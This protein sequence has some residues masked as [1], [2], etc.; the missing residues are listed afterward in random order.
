MLRKQNWLNWKKRSRTNGRQCLANC[1]SKNDTQLSQLNYCFFPHHVSFFFI[2]I[3]EY[4]T[5]SFSYRLYPS[6]WIRLAFFIGLSNRPAVKLHGGS[7]LSQAWCFSRFSTSSYDFWLHDVTSLILHS[8][9]LPPNANTCTVCKTA[10]HCYQIDLF[11]RLYFNK[12]AELKRNM[13]DRS[14]PMRWM[15]RF[16]FCVTTTKLISVLI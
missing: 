8:F 14:A 11:L 9:Q 5:L 4:W 3:S 10:I 7:G 15:F 16:Q 2:L 1:S 6:I 12:W 13:R